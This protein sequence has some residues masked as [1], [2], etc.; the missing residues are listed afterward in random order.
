MRNFKLSRKLK[1]PAVSHTDLTRPDQT[2]ICTQSFGHRLGL[3][4]SHWDTDFLRTW[5]LAKSSGP[6]LA[7]GQV[8][9]TQTLTDSDLHRLDIWF[10]W[11]VRASAWP[12]NAPP[13]RCHGVGGH[14]IDF[15]GPVARAPQAVN[16]CLGGEGHKSGTAGPCTCTDLDQTQTWL[17]AKSSGHR[18]GLRPSPKD[19]DF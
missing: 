3:R 11:A 15:L 19:T 6:D 4:P 10:W 7:F 14:R 18:L 13:K 1:E 8:L 5:P 16:C 17:S 2:C 9:Q 12:W